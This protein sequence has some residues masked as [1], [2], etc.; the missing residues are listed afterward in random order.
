MPRE[1][2]KPQAL[3]RKALKK[4]PAR[5][6]TTATATR[7][8]CKPASDAI[9]SSETNNWNENYLKDDDSA[10]SSSIDSWYKEQLDKQNNQWAAQEE[11]EFEFWNK[12]QNDQQEENW[13]EQS[14]SSASS[15]VSSSS[16]STLDSWLQ[17]QL[18]KQN[19]QWAQE[20][21]EESNTNHSHEENRQYHYR[22]SHQFHG[23]YYEDAI[24]QDFS[25]DSED[26]E[27]IHTNTKRSYDHQ[28]SEP[29]DISSTNN[30]LSSQS[31]SIPHHPREQGFLSSVAVTP[32]GSI[33]VKSKSK[34]AKRA[35]STKHTRSSS[36]QS[37]NKYRQHRIRLYKEQTFATAHPN[38]KTSNSTPNPLVLF[39][40]EPEASSQQHHIIEKIVLTASN[41]KV[42]TLFQ[43]IFRNITLNIEMVS[44]QDNLCQPV[45]IS[46]HNH[47][48]IYELVSLK[49]KEMN[50]GGALFRGAKMEGRMSSAPAINY[51]YIR[52]K[53]ASGK[54]SYFDLASQLLKLGDFEA[55]SIRKTVARFE[56][57]QSKAQCTNHTYYIKTFPSNI[58]S[59][60]QEDHGC[61]G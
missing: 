8:N 6:R 52:T 56:L 50:K 15:L 54:Q 43:Y 4:S 59:L 53:D 13:E 28:D 21:F 41:N 1:Q 34:R 19:N 39:E 10:A 30:S 12:K 58:F 20:D 46:I 32:D 36:K 26:P 47:D 38:H 57:L 33:S 18:H 44:V 37:T 2:R 7:T 49:D 60:Q 40:K 42:E 29:E 3:K 25:S 35:K 55:L 51:V 14:F 23:S 61:A 24:F 9:T 31:L 11:L 27:S 16:S 45:P 48:G 17:Q 5:S 22:R